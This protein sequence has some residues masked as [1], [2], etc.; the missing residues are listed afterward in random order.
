MS[1]AC[2][3]FAKPRSAPA[4]PQVLKRASGVEVS[5][6]WCQLASTGRNAHCRQPFQFKMPQPADSRI[7]APE[8]INY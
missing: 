7:C 8:P 2:D 1:P 3:T 4:D 6:A 5:G